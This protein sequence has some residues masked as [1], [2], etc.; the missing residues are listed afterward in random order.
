MYQNT[1]YRLNNY[2]LTSVRQLEDSCSISNCNTPQLLTTS[3]TNTLNNTNTSS[4]NNPNNNPYTPMECR[5]CNKTI[6]SNVAVPEGTIP[7]CNKFQRD[8][9]FE[10]P[11]NL[12]ESGRG[13]ANPWRGFPS[14]MCNPFVMKLPKNTLKDANV[15][16]NQPDI[17]N[18][19][20]RQNIDHKYIRVENTA[21]EPILVGIDIDM[22]IDSHIYNSNTKLNEM[23]QGKV[24]LLRSGESRDLG[25]NQVGELEQFLFL[26][27][28]E[29]KRMLSQ[30][31]LI[32]RHENLFS[33]IKGQ[34]IWWIMPFFRKGW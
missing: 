22:N 10:A 28:P 7:K 33:I 13:L 5:S 12:A 20:L 6:L 2:Q 24:F 15:L 14:L 26:Y 25:I 19:S 11:V 32:R 31:F 8:L 30:P 9:N 4:C 34:N 23:H 1:P 17:N 27:H 21:R 29:T 16:E 3:N 18:V